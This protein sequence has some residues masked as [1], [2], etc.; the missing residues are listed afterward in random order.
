ML[1]LRERCVVLLININKRECAYLES[2][3]AKWQ[4]DLH[5]T[6]SSGH[7]LYITESPRMKK[8]LNDYRTSITINPEKR[9]TPKSK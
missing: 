6:Y 8:L 5:R 9:D 4:Q 3:G 7:K 2:K 1:N